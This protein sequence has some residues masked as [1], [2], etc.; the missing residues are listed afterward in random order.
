VAFGQNETGTCPH[1]MLNVRFESTE[2]E[3]DGHSWGVQDPLR[4]VT[5]AGF[6]LQVSSSGCPGCGKPIVRATA[7]VPPNSNGVLFDLLLWPDSGIR[8]V[9]REVDDQDPALTADF[10]EAAAVL[11]KSK[12]ASAALSR[13][14]L[15][16]RNSK[17]SRGQDGP[18]RGLSGAWRRPT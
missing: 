7:L 6:R 5:P 15:R 4:I 17:G 3:A 1:C 18:S 2:I 14:C 12:K 9:P 13:R 8:P 10:R 11:Q 16:S